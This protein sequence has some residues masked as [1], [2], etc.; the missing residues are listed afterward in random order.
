MKSIAFFFLT[1]NLT[2][3]AIAKDSISNMII[4][5]FIFWMKD[6]ANIQHFKSYENDTPQKFSGWTFPTNYLNDETTHIRLYNQEILGMSACYNDSAGYFYNIV[7]YFDSS[8]SRI[9]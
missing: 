6:S 5:D 1:I 7:I 8:K 4:T 2:F 9:L 3:P